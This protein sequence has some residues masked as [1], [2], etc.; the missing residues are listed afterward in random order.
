MAHEKR[1]VRPGEK[2]GHVRLESG[3]EVPPP[4][5]WALLPPGDAGLTRRVKAAGPSWTIKEKKGRRTF[6]R[7]VLAPAENIERARAALEAE[8]A[9]P[10]YQRKLAASRARRAKEHEAYV[11]EFRAEVLAFLAFAPRYGRLAEELASAVTAHATPVGSGT[12]ARTKRI[13]VER[14]AEAAVIA[15]MRHQT[16]AYDDM[17]IERR[18]GA[19]R[20]VRRA[21]AKR[22]RRLL[23]RYRAGDDIDL[24]ACPLAAGFMI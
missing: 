24:S 21:L 23:Q 15:W 6:S 8:R 14:R 18:K 10:A 12:V 13:S 20:E 2:A 16:T 5:G 1:E 9:T 4:A 3:K 11:K 17:R 22:S 19:R 7:G